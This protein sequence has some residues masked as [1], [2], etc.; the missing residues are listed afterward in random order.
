MYNHRRKT[1]YECLWTTSSTSHSAST[2][3]IVAPQKTITGRFGLIVHSWDWDFIDVHTT[4]LDEPVY[5]DQTKIVCGS[6]PVVHEYSRDFFDGTRMYVRDMP[7]RQIDDSFRPTRVHRDLDEDH[8][9]ITQPSRGT[10]VLK[11]LSISTNVS[12]RVVHRGEEVVLTRGD[13][14]EDRVMYV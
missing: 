9:E 13:V 1:S 7:S 10:F 8:F 6:R 11:S 14:I 12:G 3:A 2:Q 5:S 4:V